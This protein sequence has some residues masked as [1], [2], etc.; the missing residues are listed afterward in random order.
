MEPLRD[1]VLQGNDA[2]VGISPGAE[3]NLVQRMAA[4]CLANPLRTLGIVLWRGGAEALQE[5]QAE[6]AERTAMAE[7]AEE[8]EDQLAQLQHEP[9]A[10]QQSVRIFGAKLA[11]LQRLS[12]KEGGHDMPAPLLCTQG[13]KGAHSSSFEAPASSSEYSS[14]SPV[15]FSAVGASSFEFD[16]LMS[17]D[18][19]WQVV[20]HLVLL[21]QLR[22]LSLQAE[23]ESALAGKRKADE[24]NR[25]LQLGLLQ[26]QKVLEQALQASSHAEELVASGQQ[27]REMLQVRFEEECMHCRQQRAAHL[28]ESKLQQEL[29]EEASDARQRAAEHQQRA[30][31]A[32][33]Q[34]S[35]LHQELQEEVEAHR[36]SRAALVAEHQAQLQEQ[37]ALSELSKNSTTALAMQEAEAIRGRRSKR[38][39]RAERRCWL[40]TKR[41]CRSSRPV[42][43][44][45]ELLNEL[46]EHAEEAQ[47]KESNLE[48]GLQEEIEAHQKSR[49][50]LTAE[51]QAQLQEQQ[52]LSELSKNSTT[53]LAMQEAEA[54]DAR[55]RAAEHQQRARE[56]ELQESK[57]ER[58]LQE[59]LEAH[60]TSRA[61]LVAEYQEKLQEQ[62]AMSELSKHSAT[63][64][65]E[66]EAVQQQRVCDM[67]QSEVAKMQ[68]MLSTPSS[69][70]RPDQM[71]AEDVLG[72]AMRDDPHRAAS[73]TGLKDDR[74]Q[75]AFHALSQMVNQL[76]QRLHFAEQELKDEMHS[77]ISPS[78]EPEMEQRMAAQELEELQAERAERR[79]MAE[80]AE[81]RL[82]VLLESEVTVE[83]LQHELAQKDQEASEIIEIGC[84]LAQELEELQAERAERRAMAEEAEERLSSLPEFEVTVEQLQ[85]ELTQKDQEASEIIEIGC[86]LAQELEELQA[87]RAERRAMAEEAEERLSVLQESEVTAAS[88]ARQLAAEHQ[89]R[90]EQ[91]ELQ[92]SKLERELRAEVE[93]NQNSGAALVAEHQAQLQELQAMSEIAE[94]LAMQEAE[95][96]LGEQ[97][98]ERA[99]RGGGRNSFAWAVVIP[100]G[101]SSGNPVLLQVQASQKSRAALAAE[102]QAQLQEQ[103]AMSEIATA[104][105]MQ[106]AEASESRQQAAE[107]QKRA[108]EAELQESK[109]AR[110]LRE[111]GEA[112]QKSRAALVAE[113]QAL[114]QEQRAPVQAIGRFD[115]MNQRASEARQRAAEYQQRAKEAELQESKLE[116]E[117][118]D[119]V[120]VMSEIA[121]VLAMQ[122]AE[123]TAWGK[124]KLLILVDMGKGFQQ[125]GANEKSRAALVAE[126]QALLQ[127]QRASE[128]RQRAAEHQ[129]RAEE[130]EF[131]E[132]QLLL[133]RELR[134]EVEANEK[135]R[136]ALVAEHQA[137]LQEQSATSAISEHAAAAL[138]IQEAEA[139][140][141]R[142]QA[143]EHQQRAKEAELQESNLARELREEVDAGH[144]SR[145]ALVAEQQALLQEQRESNL[146]RELREEASHRSRAAVVAEQQALLQEQRASEARQRAAEHQPRA[147]EA[148]LQ[149]SKSERELREEVKESQNSRVAL[150]A[151]CQALLEKQ[152]A[153]S[154]FSMQHSTVALAIR[155]AEAAQQQRIC[156]MLQSEVA[157]MEQLSSTPSSQVR[158]EQVEAEDI[159]GHAVP[160]APQRVAPGT[161][162]KDDQMQHVLNSLSRLTRKL[163]QRLHLAEQE[164][165]DEMRCALKAQKE[166][167]DQ[168]MQ[169]AAALADKEAEM[170]KRL[171]QLER[172]RM[173]SSRK[174]QSLQA[175]AE[176][177]AV[178][179]AVGQAEAKFEE[180]M[181]QL[182]TEV[183]LEKSQHAANVSQLKQHLIQAGIEA[184]IR[185]EDVARMVH[186]ELQQSRQEC[187]SLRR[188]ASATMTAELVA[189]KEEAAAVARSHAQLLSAKNELQDELLALQQQSVVDLAAT[190]RS[191]RAAAALRSL[192][193]DIRHAEEGAAAREAA[194]IE[195]LTAT[196]GRFEIQTTELEAA[197]SDEL[198]SEQ[199]L[200]AAH[201]VQCMLHDECGALTA[202]VERAATAES[203]AQA[204]A[205]ELDEQRQ[206]LRQECQR[207]RSDNVLLRRQLHGGSPALQDIKIVAAARGRP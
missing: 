196:R 207:L 110:E 85:H 206:V 171:A 48:R 47:V 191:E 114:L 67:L 153:T 181:Q 205:A 120:E 51:Y 82:S 99:A 62:Q 54:S 90:A 138:A 146:A 16:S 152:Q 2:K 160:G 203:V 10:L 32:E 118:Q 169:Q 41:T 130:A 35:K 43:L 34:E 61:A 76:N 45:S 148:E 55:Q 11:E 30:R 106:E 91:A 142:H 204:R 180:S 88:D 98:G 31:E 4:S 9:A 201:E 155:E 168:R 140:E 124:D 94:A 56:A 154:Q 115:L 5:L 26:H 23:L 49:V 186:F 108:E 161:D 68:Q 174:S 194:A 170:Q 39:R 86:T 127:E 193:A 18:S 128:A 19:M 15:R 184:Q 135:S 71:E 197:K 145:A 165:K 158:P 119:E 72:P 81:E 102:C 178:A 57:L 14:P 77:S 21:S 183:S 53:A 12:A 28:Q 144:R 163:T 136:A 25:Q 46:Q 104:L 1:Q 103:Q 13:E 83:Q 27:Q 75:G 162:L 139:S 50:A 199:L 198:R 150:V 166:V 164:L 6:R 42:R 33:L 65:Q 80:E 113:Q 24:E 64:L 182:R 122:E 92:E 73:G 89:Q 172:G 58:Q 97:A 59:E 37:Q 173:E 189:I 187:D 84:T 105:A 109:L 69:P 125:A 200:H 36:M 40:N 149:E 123:A 151:E 7:E 132:R 137:L 185:E 101:V 133:E 44:Y 22:P 192:V 156:D 129:P 79:A 167:Q 134:E 117:L 66:A 74:V 70:V 143:A 29:R 60:H 8:Y 177:S 107:L 195:E 63:A 93:A 179:A 131:Q 38:I 116:R 111:E 176:N 175:E 157:K 87:E 96:Q 78:T 126:H 121:T 202:H 141:A 20:L 17:A 100:T 188:D 52:A 112:N 147:Q 159:F 190:Q 3:T 95:A